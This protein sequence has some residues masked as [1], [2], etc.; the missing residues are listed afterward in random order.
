[1]VYLPWKSFLHIYFGMLICKFHP[2]FN[3]G[4]II[5]KVHHH[6][7][8]GRNICMCLWLIS[9]L[10]LRN[11]YLTWYSRNDG[12]QFLLLFGILNLKFERQK[13]AQ[14][15]FSTT[16][17]RRVETTMIWSLLLEWYILRFQT[18]AK[19]RHFFL[20]TQTKSQLD[21]LCLMRCH[22]TYP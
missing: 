22:Q 4:F 20:R 21:I 7:W 9:R 19:W 12:N 11:V 1:M 17:T 8:N 18:P 3:S 13:I 16:P 15:P 10:D 6:F 2:F 14:Y 5:Q